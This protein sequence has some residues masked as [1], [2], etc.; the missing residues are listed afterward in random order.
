MCFDVT[1][2]RCARRWRKSG[3]K[4][5]ASCGIGPTIAPLDAAP[6]NH[7]QPSELNEPRDALRS[8]ATRI[9]DAMLADRHRLRSR[10]HGIERAAQRGADV[11]E[12]L[13]KLHADAE[14]SASVLRER[15]ANAPR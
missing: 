2:R 6:A 11:T 1:W 12:G 8:L 13:R 3:L 9:D 7:P 14:R 10:L 15:R 4:A 5:V